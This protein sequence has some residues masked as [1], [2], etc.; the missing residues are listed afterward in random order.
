MGSG[1]GII[2]ILLGNLGK[3]HEFG[4]GGVAQWESVCLA[5]PRYWA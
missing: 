2:G 1:E 5:H 3:I 4:L